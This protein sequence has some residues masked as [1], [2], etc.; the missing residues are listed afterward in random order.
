VQEI[1]DRNIAPPS[2]AEPG[3]VPELQLVKTTKAFCTFE[4]PEIRAAALQ[5]SA[6]AHRRKELAKNVSCGGL[7]SNPRDCFTGG[8]GKAFCDHCPDDAEG[9]QR[10]CYELDAKE[11]GL[12]N[13]VLASTW[14]DHKGRDMKAVTK[15][16]SRCLTPEEFA[17]AKGLMQEARAL[18]EGCAQG[19]RVKKMKLKLRSTQ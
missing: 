19:P 2:D 9:I 8:P 5:Q 1:I 18:R 12:G 17:A 6:A 15:R 4:T 10:K 11:L 3:W 16:A 14:E 13:I 7:K